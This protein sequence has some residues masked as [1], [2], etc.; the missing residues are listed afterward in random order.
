M[1]VEGV[2]YQGTGYRIQ[3]EHCCSGKRSAKQRL[4]YIA[5]LE[6]DSFLI[7]AEVGQSVRG[8]VMKNLE[9]GG[10]VFSIGYDDLFGFSDGFL[11]QRMDIDVRDI[12]DRIENMHGI[13]FVKRVPGHTVLQV[14]DQI[15]FSEFVFRDGIGVFRILVGYRRG[16][17]ADIVIGQIASGE[18]RFEIEDVFA[19]GFIVDVDVSQ[20][21]SRN[22]YMT[23]QD[24]RYRN[25]KQCH[26]YNQ[27]AS[28]VRQADGG[29]MGRIAHAQHRTDADQKQKH[30]TCGDNA[31]LRI[32][33]TEIQ[34]GNIR[35]EKSQ[36]YEQTLRRSHKA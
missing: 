35:Q 10:R 13:S 28:F 19:Y 30:Q 8:V 15:F 32:V 3:Q 23:S 33:V 16:T 27:L 24:S 9:M 11:R 17:C 20:R 18:S 21:L 31:E 14:S 1:G 6:Q 25:G 4:A 22:R 2:L 5:L 26:V 12:P 34:V 36:A 7:R 29:I